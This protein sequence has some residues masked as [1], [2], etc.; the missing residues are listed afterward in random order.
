MTAALCRRTGPEGERTKLNRFGVSR[1]G[2]FGFHELTRIQFTLDRIHYEAQV[3]IMKPKNDRYLG[4]RTLWLSMF[5]LLVFRLASDCA[6]CED[7][8]AAP[9]F[10]RYGQSEA[11]T[12]ELKFHTNK[13][14]NLQQ[15]NLL[16]MS[17]FDRGLVVVHNAFVNESGVEGECTYWTFNLRSG[18]NAVYNLS[19]LS[20]DKLQ[21]LR[22]AIDGLPIGISSR[23]LGRL[24]MVSFS[25]GTNWVTRCY[26]SSTLPK[27][28]N[29]IGEILRIELE[30]Q[31]PL[32]NGF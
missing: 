19:Q 18:G 22:L 14:W 1:N 24:V 13:V 9:D 21:P 17:V 5:V 15:T 3:H 8:N 11:F 23:P 4:H 27:A 7:T 2:P 30:E 32:H 28:V 12:D 31:T 20:K 25:R 10:S 26:D 29:Q 6:R 16:M